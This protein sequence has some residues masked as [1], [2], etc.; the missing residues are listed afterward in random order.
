MSSNEDENECFIS[1][2]QVPI[3]ERKAL[4]QHVVSPRNGRLK[5]LRAIA[6]HESLLLKIVKG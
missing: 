3:L 2:Y 6:E 1:H 4:L 5:I